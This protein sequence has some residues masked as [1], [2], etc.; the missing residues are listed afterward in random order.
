MEYIKTTPEF[1]L[2]STETMDKLIMLSGR[3]Q[4]GVAKSKGIVWS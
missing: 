3:K 1:R 4:P 2:N